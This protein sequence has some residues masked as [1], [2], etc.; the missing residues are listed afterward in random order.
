MR[1]WWENDGQWIHCA[2][3]VWVMRVVCSIPLCSQETPHF[4][5]VVPAGSFIYSLWS[6]S[7]SPTW[8]FGHVHSHE[9][10]YKWDFTWIYAG[11][12]LLNGEFM[13]FFHCQVARWPGW[14]SPNPTAQ[15]L[16][17][18]QHG[19]KAAAKPRLRM[20]GDHSSTISSFIAL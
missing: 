4:I 5:M 11:I 7:V 19:T 12:Y 2:G 20:S 17:D 16:W 3:V 18:V 6:T 8:R 14:T 15:L 10:F 13:W 9:I 1:F